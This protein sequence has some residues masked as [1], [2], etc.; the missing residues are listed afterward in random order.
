LCIGTLELADGRQVKGFLCEPH[1]LQGALDITDAGSWL[2]YHR[3]AAA[4]R[5]G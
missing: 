5:D 1:G 4:D 3:G 2:R